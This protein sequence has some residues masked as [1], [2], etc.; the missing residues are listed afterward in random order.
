VLNLSLGGVD[1]SDGT[2]AGSQAINAAFDAG[3]IPLVAAGNDGETAYIS[4]PAAADKALTI[5]ALADQN[6]LGRDDDR[7]ADFSNEGPRTADGDADVR[8]EMKPLV[9]GPGAGIVSADGSLITDGRNYKI[10]SGTSMSTPHVAGVVAL[11][12]EANP[13]LTPTQVVEILRHTSE[14][15]DAWGK[16]PAASDPFPTEDPNYHPSGGWGQVDAYAAVKEAL[17]LAGDPAS[18]TQVVRIQGEPADNG[19]AAIDLT[20]T[21]QRETDLAGYRVYRADDVGGAPGVWTEITSATVPGTG[22]AAIEGLP[23]RNVYTLRDAGLAFGNIYWY[24]VEH[25]ST[26]PAV[27]TIQE[28]PLA[29]VLG[30]PR[31]VARIRYSI[32]HDD[33]DNDLLVLIGTG[34]ELARP[35]RVFDGKS[36]GDADSVTEETGEPTLGTLRHEFTVDLTSLDRIEGH[37]PP[38]KDNPWFLTVKEGGFVN[39]AGRVNAFSITLFDDDGNPTD[40]YSTGDLAPRQT[41][42][43]R[44][45]TLWIPDDPTVFLPGDSPSVSFVDPGGAA[46]G[47]TIDAEVLGAE[48]LPGANVSVSGEGVTVDGVQYA[49]GARLIATLVVAADAAAGP[50]DVTVTNLDGGS[51]TAVG[52]FTVVGEGD[53][54]DGGETQVVDLDNG[55]PAI[56]YRTG[57]HRTESAE[58][59]SGG[60]H[61]RM[62]GNGNGANPSA[63]LVFTGHQVTY[64]YAV[65]S[66]GGEADV[67]LDGALVDTVSF[68]GTG[69]DPVFGHSVTY[70][71]TGSGEHELVIEHR[72]GAVYVD[73]FRIASNG[74]EDP[75][76]DEDAPQT[77]SVTEVVEDSL[78]A[79]GA[80]LIPVSVHPLDDS[81]SV[82]IEGAD[83]TLPVVLLD[84]T[85]LVV[86]TVNTLLPGTRLTGFDAAPAPGTYTLQVIDLLAAGDTVQ[87][88]V[89][90]T[91]R[92][93]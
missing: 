68:S 34:P 78:N 48:F 57:W 38:S 29:V 55:D 90:R 6:T 91:V 10:L 27:G 82:L 17:R 22:G 88:S 32:T 74:D 79:I 20:W 15:R 42:E 71:A 4:S 66:K 41:L 16:T 67:Y 73:G 11:L 30:Q 62:G 40:S 75:T 5:G 93:R 80:L 49:S 70:E 7:I 51:D 59:S 61:R 12:L 36:V 52:A 39:R 33:I 83:R 85:G 19:S 37:L 14:H 84:S 92:V 45:T 64:H 3:L 25:T 76:A 9:A 1:S 89:A 50:R 56:E 44:N 77:R 18:R 47:A 24:R 65:S 35:A 2:D 87:I 46:R 13:A 23:N 69:K 43:G 81:I 26:D 8:D 53:G 31:P 58:A 21:S 72:S 28:P 54:G 60:Y 86:A 63:R